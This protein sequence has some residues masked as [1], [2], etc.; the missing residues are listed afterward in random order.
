[1]RLYLVQHG[2]AVP[3]ETDPKRPL[4]EKGRKD[5]MKLADFLKGGGVNI[6][7]IWHSDKTRAVETARIFA[8]SLHVK[9]SVEERKDLAPN[10]PV[11]IL[12]SQILSLQKDLMIVGHLPFLQKLVHHALLHTDSAGII[13]FFMAGVVCLELGKKGTWQLV[14]GVMP[15]LI[16]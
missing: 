1:M 9:G 4:S 2:E 3:A 8:E 14:F 11:D 5:A 15:E 10:D 7:I 12:Y 13:R 16:H 6:D